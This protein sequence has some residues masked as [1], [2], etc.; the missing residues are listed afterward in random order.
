MKLKDEVCY[1]VTTKIIHTLHSE[2]LQGKKANN[3]WEARPFPNTKY[4]NY[5]KHMQ[6]K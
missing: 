2:I 5:S 1:V 6:M 3:R 4:L